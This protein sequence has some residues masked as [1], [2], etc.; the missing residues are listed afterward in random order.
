[1]GFLASAG[2]VVKCVDLEGVE[3][4]WQVTKMKS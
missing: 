4:Y 3:I 1:M 2:F